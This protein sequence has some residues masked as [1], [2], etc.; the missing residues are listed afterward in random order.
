[1]TKTADTEGYL[2]KTDQDMP[3]AMIESMART[4]I[5][6]DGKPWVHPSVAE[7]LYLLVDELKK[8]LKHRESLP[9]CWALSGK[10]CDCG[11]QELL[12]LQ[13]DRLLQK[14]LDDEEQAH[15]LGG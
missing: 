12:D 7:G 9:K 11:V 5:A 10:E 3:L 6:W 14:K 13:P 1:M 15:Q 4:A 2:I 8:H